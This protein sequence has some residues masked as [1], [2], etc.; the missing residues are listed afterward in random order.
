[1][2]IGLDFDEPTPG[3]KGHDN[4]KYMSYAIQY[5]VRRFGKDRIL[6]RR[7]SS[8]RGYHIRVIGVDVTS[9]EEMSIRTLLN[10]CKGR[11]ISDEGRLDA[12][13]RT[14]RL[15]RYKGKVNLD[16][17]YG[18]V[19]SSTVRR[20]SKWRTVKATF[21]CPECNHE[22]IIGTHDID[23]DGNVTPSVVCSCGC[24]CGFHEFVTLKGWMNE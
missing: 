21:I 8:G 12:G 6:I 10:D 1:M 11:R 15:F 7:T 5:L 4:I 13:M 14:S 2:E 18:T 17:D 9:D 23:D 24:G 22:R 19:L 20:A 16:K 3:K